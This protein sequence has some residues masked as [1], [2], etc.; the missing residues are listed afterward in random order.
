VRL[1]A[2]IFDAWRWQAVR[3][4]APLY[5]D[6]TRLGIVPSTFAGRLRTAG[7]PGRVTICAVMRKLMHIVYGV[8]RSR[9]PFSYAPVAAM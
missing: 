6:G 9:K 4:V 7:K 3:R 2:P 8:L 5:L 1:A